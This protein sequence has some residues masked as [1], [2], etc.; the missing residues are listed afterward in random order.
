MK[1]PK[2]LLLDTDVVLVSYQLDVWEKLKS[3]YDVYVTSIV[4]EKEAQFAEDS[5]GTHG[6]HLPRQ[7]RDGEIN[8]VEATALEMA[9][10]VDNFVD[11]FSKG[12]DDGELEGLA[13]I[14]RQDLEDCRFCTG[15]T[16]GIQAA[17]MLGLGNSTISLEEAMELA[18]IKIDASK[19]IPAQF[20]KRS[21]NH[22]IN[23]GA[24]RRLTCECF[25]RSPF[26]L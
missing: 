9:Q 17:G 26:G 5:T 8:I 21:H 23:L 16:N 25:K 22:H 11:A 1:K 19:K 20:T 2:L 12:L 18:G 3:K 15:D 10:V 6:C 14:R 13:V 24:T 7:A 4:A